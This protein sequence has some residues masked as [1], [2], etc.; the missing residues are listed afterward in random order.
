MIQT[1]LIA[2]LGLVSLIPYIG[3]R[4][5][6]VAEALVIVKFYVTDDV[7]ISLEQVCYPGMTLKAFE[8]AFRE[9]YGI[10]ELAV[11]T[12]KS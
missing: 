1:K 11:P 5:L 3:V 12:P 2:R 10:S 9:E 6:N 7:D 8:K 4:N